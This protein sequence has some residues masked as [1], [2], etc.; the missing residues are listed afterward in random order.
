M[1]SR[2]FKGR[3]KTKTYCFYLIIILN[4]MPPIFP[5]THLA[6]DS[7][8]KAPFPKSIFIIFSLLPPLIFPP[9]ELIRREHDWEIGHEAKTKIWGG[10]GPLNLFQAQNI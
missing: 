1:T 3:T 4:Y 2:I 5:K 6:H 7:P 8:Q 10:G 9:P